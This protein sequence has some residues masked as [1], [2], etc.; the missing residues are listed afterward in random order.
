TKYLV[1]INR[2]QKSKFV[3]VA[4]EKASIDQKFA[5]SLWNQNLNKDVLR[6]SMTD[7]DRYKLGR[8]RQTRNK[9]VKTAYFHIK[10]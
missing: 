4:W 1:K 10:K 8:A 9:I 7:F 6:S 2:S 5:D 3:R